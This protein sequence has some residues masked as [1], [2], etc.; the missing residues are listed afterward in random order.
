[1]VEN[2]ILGVVVMTLCLVIQ[3]VVVAILLLALLRLEKRGTIP[4][5]LIGVS[6]LL[7][8][9]A[10]IM[11]AGTLV[12]AAVWAAVFLARGEF[13]DFATAFYHSLVNFATL[14]YGDIV[15]SERGR[16]LG[17]LEATNG[18]LMFG[19]T[20]GVLFGVFSALLHRVWDA[21]HE[22]GVSSASQ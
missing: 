20:T 5:R 11:M 15:M 12:Q 9:F 4:D 17:A 13:A 22:G 1:M 18:V 6:V 19:L 8:V 21:Q 3:C 2:L 14:G 16:L 10:L 7:A